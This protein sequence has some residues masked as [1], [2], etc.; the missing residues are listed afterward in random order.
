MMYRVVCLKIK[1]NIAILFTVN[2]TNA[3]AV[4]TNVTWFNWYFII[5]CSAPSN[6]WERIGQWLQVASQDWCWR[7]YKYEG[8]FQRKIDPVCY[9]QCP[10]TTKDSRNVRLGDVFN[11]S[12][13]TFGPTLIMIK[14]CWFQKWSIFAGILP[15]QSIKLDQIGIVK[16]DVWFSFINDVTLNQ[17]KRIWEEIFL[18][19]WNINVV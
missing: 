19:N 3:S 6:I 7:V 1:S 14:Y 2:E 12:R 17:R 13:R 9:Q 16:L 18:N 8:G 4:Q 10:I 11:S 15:Y 5:Q